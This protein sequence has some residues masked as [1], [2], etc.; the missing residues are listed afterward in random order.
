MKS[1]CHQSRRNSPS[2]TAWMPTDSCLATASRMCL[3]CTARSCSGVISPRFAFARASCSSAGRRRLPTWSARKGGV[4]RCVM[5]DSR[6]WLV[7]TAEK[8]FQAKR[9]PLSTHF[10]PLRKVG[11][12]GT[13]FWQSRNAV[14]L[15]YPPFG[16]C[17]NGSHGNR[18]EE[19][20][21]PH[22]FPN[23]PCGLRRASGVRRAR[24]GLSVPADQGHRSI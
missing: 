4:L 21:A 1:M 10:I 15:Q 6:W 9:G 7:R 12:G 14:G 11:G 8:G 19:S 5:G 18:E 24:A 20:H 17:G 23:L 13:Y 22:H 3:S 2:V 16:A